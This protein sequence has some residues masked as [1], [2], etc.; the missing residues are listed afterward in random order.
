MELSRLVMKLALRH[1]P[2]DREEWARAMQAEFEVLKKGRLAWAI[3]CLSAS[4]SWDLR[5]HALFWL[6]MPL[7]IIAVDQWVSAS[8]LFWLVK[9]CPLDGHGVCAYD[10]YYAGSLEFL[11]PCLAFGLW[12]PNRI[13]TTAMAM[14]LCKFAYTYVF[15]ALN[16]PRYHGDY[17]HIMN[18]PPVIGETVVLTGA[19]IAV[20]TGALVGR[21]ARRT[22][23]KQ[24]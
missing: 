5:A 9:H 16:F 8:L 24:P 11:V 18:M 21:G 22:L 6:A 14:V 4:L 10:A 12:R 23:L 17:I 15:F 7:S 20:A 2:K 3:G 19:L 13:I 1:V